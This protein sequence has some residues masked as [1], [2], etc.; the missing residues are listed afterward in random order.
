MTDVVDILYDGFALNQLPYKVTDYDPVGSP[1]KETKT[2]QLAREHGSKR[3][4]ER[5]TAGTIQITGEIIHPDGKVAFEQAVDTLKGWL[6][7]QSGV[8]QIQWADG[9]RRW[10]ATVKSFSLPRARQNISYAP[11]TITFEL[12]NPFSTDGTTDQ[13]VLDSN[14]TDAVKDFQFNVAG[15]MDASPQITIEVNDI[16]PDD[17]EIAMSISNLAT[18]QT[19]IIERVFQAG[20]IVSID[21][22]NYQVFVNSVFTRARGQFPEWRIGTGVLRYEDNAD[23]RDVTVNMTAERKYL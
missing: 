19:L 10:D 16:N 7:R 1:N 20:D 18:S 3:V 2:Y 21:C 8:L 17:S 5:F 4:M 22:E 13:L 14:N 11:Y 23:D 15:T 9:Y 6:R 12:T